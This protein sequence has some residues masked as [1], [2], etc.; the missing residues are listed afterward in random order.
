MA[1]TAEIPHLPHRVVVV[2]GGF[3]GS[4]RRAQPRHRPGGPPHPGRPPQLPPLPA[5]AVPG[6]DRRP[7]ARRHRPASAVARA[8]AARTPR[9]SSA[10]PSASTSSGARSSSLTAG[11]SRTTRWSSRPVPITPTSTIRNGPRSRRASRRLE[12]A[13]EIRRRILIGFEAAEREADPDRR[14]AWM[15]FVIVGGGPDRRRAGRGA[16]RDRPRHA[17]ARFPVDP[18]GRGADRPGRGDGP[19]PAAVPTGPV[20]LRAAAA[21]AARRRGPHADA[22]DRA[23][24]GRS[25]GHGPRWRRGGDRGEDRALGGRRPDRQ[26]RANGRR[27]RRRAGRSRRPRPGRAR[28]D[29][30][31]PSRD[32]RRGRRR[33]RAVEAGQGHARRGPGRDPGRDVRGQ[34]HPPPD[35]RP[36]ARS[37]PLQRPRRCRD[38][39]TA[40]GGDQHQLARAVRSTGRVHGL[41]AVAR[42]PPVLPDRVL[43]QDRRPRPLGVDLHH[44]RPWD[45]TDHR[46]EAPAAHRGARAARTW[47]RSI[48]TTDAPG[49]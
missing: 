2:G 27:G 45:A 30:S 15:T 38:H 7:V 44:P 35:P 16:R 1:T 28:P 29:H 49:T 19:G 46:G 6:R 21:P 25:P 48:R 11:R 33:G 17:P 37:V 36:A 4:E 40:V 10:R 8:Q 3:A 13:T 47:R 31:R 26:I 32:L 22:G 12:D 9:S 18:A 24:R 20:G 39:R 34:G 5:A 41:G 14:R 43:E 42:H 23:R